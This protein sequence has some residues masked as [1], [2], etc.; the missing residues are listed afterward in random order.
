M[1]GF[2]RFDFFGKLQFALGFPQNQ[3]DLTAI[4]VDRRAATQDKIGFGE[5]LEVQIE[6]FAFSGFEFTACD[7]VG[8]GDRKAEEIEQELGEG[9]YERIFLLLLKVG[10][11]RASTQ[12]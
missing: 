12:K 8:G 9:I 2:F 3:M 11:M 6:G 1:T 5:K 7:G 4:D 10:V